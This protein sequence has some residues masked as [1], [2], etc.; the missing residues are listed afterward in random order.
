MKLLKA[1]G[2]ILLAVILLA[3]C[4]LGY[5]TLTEYRPADVETVSV[6]SGAREEP[7]RVGQMLDVVTFNTGYSGLGRESDFFMDGGKQV[8]PLSEAYVKENLNGILGELTSLHP[9]ICLLQEVDVN[10]YR[11]WHIDQADTLRRGLSM[12]MAYAP[13]YRCAF[14]PFPWPPIGRVDSGLCTLT[15]LKVTEA[16]RES[17]PVP[18]SWPIRM[19]NLK[20]C[21]LVE[22]IPVAD[23]DRELVLVNLHLEAFDDGEGKIAQ[24]KQ[25]MELLSLERRKGN[26]VLVGGDFNQTFEA[27]RDAYPTLEGGYWMPGSLSDSDAPE[28]I[29]F[30][31]DPSSPTCRDLMHP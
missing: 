4:L 1:I 23:S 21:L 13:N 29:R 10:S 9:D 6:T 26:Y 30:V 5:L 7:V 15:N 16:A 11:S 19:A 22:R 28:G 8:R 18:F 20:R 2:F 3:A 25:L 27:A 14:V 31:C 17:L 24:T 12:N